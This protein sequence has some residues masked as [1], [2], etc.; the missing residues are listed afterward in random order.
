MLIATAPMPPPPS[1]VHPWPIEPGVSLR[2]T[3]A[4][5]L[6]ANSHVLPSRASNADSVLNDERLD[7]VSASVQGGRVLD[8][9]RGPSCSPGDEP[10]SRMRIAR[11]PIHQNAIQNPIHPMWN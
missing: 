11:P 5:S 1:G 6:L 3:A 10:K 9:G 2:G 4:G 7:P 8:L